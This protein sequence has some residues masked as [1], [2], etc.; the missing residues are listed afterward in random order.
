M[1]QEINT[2]VS[3]TGYFLSY[4]CQVETFGHLLLAI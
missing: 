2:T 4:V 3:G 1:V